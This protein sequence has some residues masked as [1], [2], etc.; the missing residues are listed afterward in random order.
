MGHVHSNVEWPGDL[1]VIMD[2]PTWVPRP[3]RQP[4]A[5]IQRRLVSSYVAH[6]EA[7]SNVPRTCKVSTATSVYALTQH[8]CVAQAPSP[9][10]KL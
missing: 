7:V 5:D 8:T 6:C 1:P 10:Q 2:T 3:S 9:G 4:V